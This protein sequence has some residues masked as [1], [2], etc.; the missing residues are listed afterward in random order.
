MYLLF[1]ARWVSTKTDRGTRLFSISLCFTPKGA[2]VKNCSQQFFPLLHRV[3]RSGI[4]F[5]DKASNVLKEYIR[6]LLNT[7]NISPATTPRPSL[8]RIL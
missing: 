1:F 7:H 6:E 3:R 4:L 8:I 2:N 5:R